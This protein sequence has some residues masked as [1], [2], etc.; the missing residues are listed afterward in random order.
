[1]DPSNPYRFWDQNFVDLLNSQKDSNCS[2]NHIPPNSTQS[3]QTI[4]FSNPFSSQPLNISPPF[5]SQPPNQTPISESEDCFGV[6]VDE[7]DEEGG[8]GVRKRWSAEEDVYLISAWLNTSKDPMVSKEQRKNSFWKRVAD[9][10]KAHVGGTGSNARGTSQCKARW[11]KINHQINKFVGCYAQASTRRKS[12]ESED[13][14]LRMAE[15][16]NDQKWI[17]EHHEKCGIKRTKLA[18]EGEFAATSSNGGDEMRPL[19]VKAAKKKGNKPAVS[20][21]VPD[22]SVDRLDKIIAM[23]DQEQA[24]KE[25]HGKM[26]LLDSLLN[27]SELTPAEVLLRD[28]LLDQMLTNI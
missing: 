23:K 27:K 12:G 6:T 7:I 28:K 22:G 16:K 4:Q 2:V 5:S 21:D 3:S 10:Y 15:L 9:Y 17:T 1:M 14:V 11:N 8:R 26:R 19:G 13:V 25:R 24:A 18:Y 20:S